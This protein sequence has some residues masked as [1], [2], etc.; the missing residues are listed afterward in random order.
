MSLVVDL[1]DVGLTVWD[2]IWICDLALELDLSRF[3]FGLVAV[4]G[5][6]QK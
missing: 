6:I 1:S 3:G 5:V 2:W 4:R